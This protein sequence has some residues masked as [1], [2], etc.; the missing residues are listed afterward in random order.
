MTSSEE[1]L[2]QFD[3]HILLVE[4]NKSNQVVTGFLIE[5]FGLSL[6]LAN[7]GKEAVELI[8][9]GKQYDLILMDI[10]MPVMDGFI[11]TRAIR[12]YSPT[13]IPI[14]ALSGSE[15]DNDLAKAKKAGMNDFILKPV[16]AEKLQKIFNKYLK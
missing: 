12:A 2:P 5:E 14:V 1:R 15:S 4:D 13:P 8:S 9:K 10:H 3:G 11:A 6:D 16:E 7:H